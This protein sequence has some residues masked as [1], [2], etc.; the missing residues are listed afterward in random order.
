VLLAVGL[1]LALAALVLQLAALPHRTAWWASIASVVLGAIPVMSSVVGARSDGAVDNAS[2]VAAV[3]AAA[4]CVRPDA[5]FG[6]L[7]SSGE[8]LGLVGARAWARSMSA[9]GKDM[10]AINCDGV[11]DEGATMIMYSGRAPRSLIATMVRVSPL[12]LRVRRIPLGMLTDSVAFAERGWPS[13]TVS[14][15]SLSTL[16]RVHTASDSLAA[17]RGDGIPEVSTLLA[18]AVEAL[19]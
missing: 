10:I 6:V 12:P 13:L 4:S 11:D 3:L 2:G 9:S 8:E 15:G 5:A 19:A 16:R 1:G 18:R 14:R 7:V 17:L